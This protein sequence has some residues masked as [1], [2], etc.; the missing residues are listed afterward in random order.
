ML[1]SVSP[2]AHVEVARP[3]T[4]ARSSA[5]TAP[6]AAGPTQQRGTGWQTGAEGNGTMS[7]D[8]YNAGIDSAREEAMRRL[9]G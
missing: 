2:N 4:T 6:T 5:A 8:A 9:F 3:A 7:V 1:K